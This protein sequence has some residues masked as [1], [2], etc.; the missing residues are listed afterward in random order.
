[1]CMS[2][3]NIWEIKSEVSVFGQP[4]YVSENIVHFSFLGRKG[5]SQKHAVPL[6]FVTGSWKMT[7]FNPMWLKELSK[8][9]YRDS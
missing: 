5:L 4:V 9:I 8:G 3:I 7:I 2:M 1:M 6:G